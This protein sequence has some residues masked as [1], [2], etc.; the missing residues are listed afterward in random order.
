[1]NSETAERLRALDIQ[2][3]ADIRSH[4]LFVRGE[5]LALVERTG[6]GFGMIGSTGL[7]TE[8]GV[9]YLVWR[10]GGAML[11]AKGGEVPARPE[12]VAAILRFS[13]DLKSALGQPGGPAPE[14]RSG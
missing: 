11:S 13:E 7:A 3:A 9:A 5:T 8:R 4:S 6:D 2:L 10:N 1:V 14:L 12:Q